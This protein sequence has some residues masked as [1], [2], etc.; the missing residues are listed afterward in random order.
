[1]GPRYVL[2]LFKVKNYK[3]AKNAKTTKAR[4]KISTYLESLEF[5]DVCLSKFKNN[6]ILLIKISHRFLATT[7]LFSK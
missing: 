5:F 2:Q 7:K 6:Q 4:E 3:N 1:M